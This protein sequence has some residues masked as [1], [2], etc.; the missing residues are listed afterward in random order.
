M[1]PTIV[2]GEAHQSRSTWVQTLQE[3]FVGFATTMLNI[4]MKGSKDYNNSG[5]A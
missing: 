5:L 1:L 3:F 2:H 4:H